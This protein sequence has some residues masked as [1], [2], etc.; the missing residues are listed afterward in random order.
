MNPKQLAAHKTKLIQKT[1]DA[2]P[3]ASNHRLASI[4]TN[5]YGE[6]FPTK[7]IARTTLR[8]R[9][10]KSGEQ[11]RKEIKTRAV[12]KPDR[13]GPTTFAMPR[14]KATP[15]DP[16]LI[17]SGTIAI[18]ADIHF[19]KHDEKA[20]KLAVEHIKSQ[21]PVEHLLLLGDVADAHE[22][23]AWAKSP[24]AI[25][26]AD[27]L[28]SVRQ[29]L[30]WLAS[31]F[32]KSKILYKFGNHEERLDKY[33]WQRAPELV[34][35]AHISWEGLL[36]IDEELKPIPQ[37]QKMTFVADQRPILAG[38]LPIFHGH[39]LKVSSYNPSAA[40]NRK[41]NDSVVFG[42]HHKA[43]SHSSCD[44][45]HNYTTAWSVGCLCDLRPDYARINHWSHGHAIVQVA[46]SGNFQVQNF[47]HDR[48]K[49]VPA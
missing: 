21:G 46:K 36:K 45:L 28:R 3:E 23:S 19:P 6:Y 25:D 1:I 20:L 15:W 2:N 34:G 43:T 38:R 40:A 22:F 18:L 13:S 27:S 29:G 39:E 4:L 5:K 11:L 47:R 48:G 24:K 12:V 33:C 9:L 49:V 8:R 41:L 10:G 44:W 7:E 30:I 32:P 31:Q 37:L 26:T 17:K 16:Y 14:S 35:V 42:H